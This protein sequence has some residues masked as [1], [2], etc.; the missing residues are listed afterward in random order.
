MEFQKRHAAPRLRI[1][2]GLRQVLSRAAGL[3]LDGVVNSLFERGVPSG[4]QDVQVR[5]PTWRAENEL[6][7]L[8][9]FVPAYCVGS[10]RGRLW[11][12]RERRMEYPGP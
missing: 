12:E 4:D 3:L 8:L 9:R 11:R 10:E 7:F 6:Q 2:L 1:G 5:S